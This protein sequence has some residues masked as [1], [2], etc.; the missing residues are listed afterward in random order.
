MVYATT[1][2][3]SLIVTLMCKKCHFDTHNFENSP[4]IALP[5]AFGPLV[6]KITTPQSGII[7]I[8][9]RVGPPGYWNTWGGGASCY[10][11]W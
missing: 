3:L 7:V 9:N 8:A 11:P 10:L 4:I 1:H 6:K 2:N 5:W